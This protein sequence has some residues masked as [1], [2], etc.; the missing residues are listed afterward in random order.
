LQD[1]L[2]EKQFNLHSAINKS[3]HVSLIANRST[4]LLQDCA[5]KKIQQ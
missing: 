2:F 1:C 3:V 5:G 4:F